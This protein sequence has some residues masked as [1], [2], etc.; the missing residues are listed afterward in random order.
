[1]VIQDESVVKEGLD[2]CLVPTSQVENTLW[3][4]DVACTLWEGEGII[5]R[6]AFRVVVKDLVGVDEF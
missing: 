1:M 3:R 5:D 2:M 6:G 4:N